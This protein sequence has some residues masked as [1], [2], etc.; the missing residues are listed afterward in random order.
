MIV[1]FIPVRGGS[2]SIHKKNIKPLCGKPLIYWSVAALEKTFCIDEIIIAT[3]SEEIAQTVASFNFSKVRIYDRNSE[4]ATDTASTE[5]VM[6]EYIEQSSLQDKDIFMLVQATS[7]LTQSK[8]FEKALELYKQKKYD[9]L[10]SCVRNYR[11]FWNENG[12]SKNYDYRNRPRRQ[13]FEG[14]L[15]ENGAFYINTVEG[16][17]K[18]KNRLCGDIGI[19]EMPEYTATELDDL[20]DWI[21]IEQLLNNFNHVL[22]Y[23]HRKYGKEIDMRF[24]KRNLLK[25]K[26]MINANMEFCNESLKP[27]DDTAKFECRICHSIKGKRFVNIRG[28]QYNLCE[29]CGSIILLNIPDVKTLYASEGAK[30]SAIYID[31]EVFSK[32]VENIALPKIKFI[33][34]SINKTPNEKLLWCDI[35][36]G[37]GEILMALKNV[38]YVNYFNGIGIEIDTEEIKFGIKKCLNIIEGFLVPN[39]VSSE[40]VKIISTADI[41]SM[42]NVLE[43]TEQPDQII[44]IF[45]KYMKNGAYLIIEVPRHPSLSSF[46]NLTNPNL[47]YRHIVPPIHLQVFSEKS[48]ERLLGYDFSLLATWGFGQGYTDILTNAMLVNNINENLLYQN[49]IDISN[50]VQKTIDIHG[51]S[52]QM[53]FIA[54]KKIMAN[55]IMNENSSVGDRI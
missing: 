24:L 21:I 14:Q 37:V 55:K 43:H 35:G 10:L 6:L 33:S 36:C 29:D 51:F 41:I 27:I 34:D 54:Q 9:S 11:F 50:E 18:S 25:I 42:F 26:D 39:D 45:K 49:L 15:M 4:N 12:T 52:D 30:A 32:R 19:Y 3:D 44:D 16:I 13:D 8:H 17:K 48:I 1:A 31:D 40:I 47:T 28:Y 2:K 53:I 5:S 23:Q 22:S 46:A 7:P 38:D 20:N